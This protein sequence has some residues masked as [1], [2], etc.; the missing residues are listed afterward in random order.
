MFEEALQIARGRREVKGKGERERYTYLNAEFQ[1]IARIDK[2]AFLNEQY[3]KKK[4]D[5][6]N[7]VRKTRDVFKNMGNIK[8][9]FHSRMGRI[10]D[11]D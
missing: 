1:R 10:K 7:R 9:T 6:N 11:Y 8:E 2:K 3:K 4:K 5:E